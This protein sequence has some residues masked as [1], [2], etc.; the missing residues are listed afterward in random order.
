MAGAD[1]RIQS[2]ERQSPLHFAAQSGETRVVGSLIER[3]DL[4]KGEGRGVDY[5][6][7]TA[8]IYAA[9]GFDDPELL[10][11]LLE[12]GRVAEVAEESNR[13]HEDDKSMG[14]RTV[15]ERYIDFRDC[16]GRTALGYAVLM[17]RKQNARF[18]LDMG[19]DGRIKDNHGVA[20]GGREF[21]AL[22][23]KVEA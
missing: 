1:P 7:R 19:A 17:G 11:M 6:G 13:D 18:L 23:V 5:Y 15:G 22:E 10:S 21:E 2:R 3:L 8:L 12:A 20:C 9:C 14:G 4:Q 16:H